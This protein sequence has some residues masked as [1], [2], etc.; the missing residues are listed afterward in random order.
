M[1]FCSLA[2]VGQIV[3]RNTMHDAE[4][5]CFTYYLENA[6]FLFSSKRGCDP[7][8]GSR[9]DCLRLTN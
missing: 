5:F 4:S 2:D 8:F 9:K 1:L 3:S 7:K 6:F